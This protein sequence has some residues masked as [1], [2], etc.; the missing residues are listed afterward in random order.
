MFKCVPF[1]YWISLK[2]SGKCHSFKLHLAFKKMSLLTVFLQEEWTKKFSGLVCLQ[3]QIS[4][5]MNT[6]V[7]CLDTPW[8]E[9]GSLLLVAPR[10]GLLRGPVVAATAQGPRSSGKPPASV[11]AADWTSCLF[12]LLASQP[13]SQHPPPPVEEAVMGC[14]A[15]QHS[16]PKLMP[17]R[18]VVLLT[19][20]PERRHRP[21]DCGKPVDAWN[22]REE[23]GE[24]RFRTR[25]VRP[26]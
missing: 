11:T 26:T 6:T 5:D 23:V 12:L 1:H 21:V 7:E 16:A 20:R 9:I 18:A 24:R 17:T 4:C 15:P 14:R 3:S 13:L 8:K 10:V 19:G 22:Y 2:C 25:L